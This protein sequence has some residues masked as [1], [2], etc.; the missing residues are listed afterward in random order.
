M[1]ATAE[2]QRQTGKIGRNS[3][4]ELCN[5]G[6]TA[7]EIMFRGFMNQ[8][9]P[10][11]LSDPHLCKTRQDNHATFSYLHHLKNNQRSSH[12]LGYE[13][14]CARISNCRAWS[15]YCSKGCTPPVHSRLHVCTINNLQLLPGSPACR[16][17]HF[18]I[19]T[20]FLGGEK[21]STSQV[22]ILTRQ[23]YLSSPLSV[24]KGYLSPPLSSQR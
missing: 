23:R 4:R 3:R 16:K 12:E 5:D 7:R 24:K 15:R 13:Y 6:R 18:P 1:Y 8:I 22:D 11:N 17:L 10:W 20:T 2:S 21:R 19:Q 9:S 14:E